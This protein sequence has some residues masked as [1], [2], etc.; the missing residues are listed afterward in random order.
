MSTRLST[1][2]TN[3]R[4]GRRGGVTESHAPSFAGL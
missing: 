1:L 2:D 4:T 3:S